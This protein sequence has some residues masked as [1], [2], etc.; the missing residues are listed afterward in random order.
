MPIEH[1]APETL[2][3]IFSHLIEVLPPFPGDDAKAL[4]YKQASSRDA[5]Q[6]RR[7]VGLERH[8]ASKY[9]WSRRDILTPARVNRRFSDICAELLY[10][11]LALVDDRGL[12]NSRKLQ[13]TLASSGAALQQR[14]IQL[15]IDYDRDQGC[16]LS[17]PPKQLF[18]PS[19]LTRLKTLEL[20]G[21]VGRFGRPWPMPLALW[22]RAIPKLLGL[23]R[24]VLRDLDIVLRNFADAN[25]PALGVTDLCLY[26]CPIT[27]GISIIDFYKQ[28][29]FF[30]CFPALRTLTIGG[31]APELPRDAHAFAPFADTLETFTWFDTGASSRWWARAFSTSMFPLQAC[32]L[33]AAKHLKV[34]SLLELMCGDNEGCAF[35]KTVETIELL[36]DGFDLR[37]EPRV[38]TK[39]GR[40]NRLDR[41]PAL[42]PPR[43]R[44]SPGEIETMLKLPTPEEYE[45][46]LKF[47]LRRCR[48]VYQQ[49]R[50]LDIR[51][52]DVNVVGDWYT[53]RTEEERDLLRKLALDFV[54]VFKEDLDVIL[55]Q[56]WS[57]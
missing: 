34:S 53:D 9:E 41:S 40:W 43:L 6:Y 30:Q 15:R 20:S 49:V 1:L 36:E 42:N 54:R 26:N 2:F 4:E 23:E 55:L 48:D 28:G 5:G 52:I 31:V 47:L 50:V 35:G 56:C 51:A 25:I 14:V 22:F 16:W 38:L 11:H 39:D 32:G 3:A 7:S 13:A 57:S 17:M 45:T 19:G 18:D 21:D 24:L 44:P 8:R 12:V 33:R 46:L 27:S 37:H 29:D 10:R